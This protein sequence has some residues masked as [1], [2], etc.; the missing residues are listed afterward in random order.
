[1]SVRHMRTLQRI[2]R[3]FLVSY[4]VLEFVVSHWEGALTQGLPLPNAVSR[5][6]AERAGQQ[7]EGT[8][9]IRLFAEFEAMLRDHLAQ[10]SPQSA[11]TP[12]ATSSLLIDQTYR[13]YRAT[14]S[15]ALYQS[16]HEMRAL[17]NLLAHKRDTTGREK[18]FADVL[19]VL[20]RW[21]EKL[22]ES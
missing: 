4:A 21:V 16:V 14:I 11:P 19:S 1:M 2:E 8:F 5:A 9:T 13:L 6:D 10:V 18:A 22:P 20:S 3:E 17:R 12:E 7:I 15:P